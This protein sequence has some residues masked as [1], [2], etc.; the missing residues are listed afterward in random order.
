MGT[1]PLESESSRCQLL[2]EQ[3]KSILPGGTQL[4]S[5]RPELFAPGKWP[6]YFRSANGCEI[7]DI[8]GR[9]YVD[10]SISG[11]GSCLL[12]YADPDVTAAVVERVQSGSMCTLNS[13]EE[14][15]LAQLLIE[16]HPWAEQVRYARAGGEIMSVA[17]RIARAHTGRDLVA[18]CGYHGWHDWYLAAN[19]SPADVERGTSQGKARALDEHLLPGLAPLGV[20]SQLAG[21]VFPFKYN[22]LEEL[23]EIASRHGSQIAAVIMES[24]RATPPA[25]GFLEGVREICD[26]IGAVLI[27]D[28]IT[29]GW[30]LTL[31]G[32]HLLYGVEPD[33]AAFAKSFSNGHAMAAVIGKRRVMDCAQDSFISSTYW[34]ESVGPTAALATLRK[35]QRI[36]VPTHVARIGNLFREGFAAASERRG[37]PITFSG[38]PAITSFAFEADDPLALLTL[39]TVRMLERGFLAGGSLFATLAH[40][41]SH[42]NSYL[43]AADE[44]LVEIKEAIDAGDART[45]LEG[46]VRRPHFGRLT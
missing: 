14:V 10:M 16:I 41:D 21:T 2:Y 23:E 4:F 34:T 1:A 22:A 6:A 12:G 35:M 36:D 3:A 7:T 5:K 15:E 11:I 8:D 42:V 30:R 45:R 44:V 29:V 40:Q 19:V 43:A 39:F 9:R 18:L 24:T 31:G 13:P 46:G 33:M 17:T 25:S 27:F 38:Y 28:E 32:A 26:R 37:V 20:P